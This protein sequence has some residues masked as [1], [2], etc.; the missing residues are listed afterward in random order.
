MTVVSMLVPPVIRP[1]IKL[2]TRLVE[3]ATGYLW[4][5]VGDDF[6]DT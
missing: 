1:E 3:S 5:R 2:W 4:S 6:A